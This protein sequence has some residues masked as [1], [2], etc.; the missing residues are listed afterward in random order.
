MVSLSGLFVKA[1]FELFLYV[2]LVLSV[3]QVIGYLSG[4]ETGLLICDV[5]GD[6]HLPTF[7]TRFFIY[8]IPS[9]PLSFEREGEE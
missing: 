3:F 2:L 8:L 9:V 5:L 1:Y 6:N 4:V 7:T